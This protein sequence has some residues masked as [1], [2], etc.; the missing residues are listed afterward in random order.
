MDPLVVSSPSLRSALARL[1][2][3]TCGYAPAVIP[4]AITTAGEER[5]YA[6]LIPLPFRFEVHHFIAERTGVCPPLDGGTLILTEAQAREVIHLARSQS[7]VADPAPLSTI[8]T[9]RIDPF[10]SAARLVLRNNEEGNDL[11]V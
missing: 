2:D 1:A 10:V 5:T 8:A 6:A 3:T 9:G 11:P 4:I 7:T